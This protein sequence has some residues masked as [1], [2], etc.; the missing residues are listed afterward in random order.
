MSE[1]HKALVRRFWEDVWPSGDAS[2]LVEILHPDSVNHEAPDGDSSVAGTTR[3]MFWLRSAF[4][5]QR[6]EVHQMIAEG[7][8]VAVT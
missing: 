2:G 4:S 7:D 3:T 8:A 5:E 1:H 6:Y